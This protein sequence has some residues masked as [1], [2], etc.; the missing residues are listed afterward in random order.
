[1]KETSI[2]QD[3]LDCIGIIENDYPGFKLIC[4]LSGLNSYYFHKKNILDKLHNTIRSRHDLL[5]LGN[6]YLEVFHDKHLKLFDPSLVDETAY[7]K[8]LLTNKGPKIDFLNHSICYVKLPSFNFRFTKKLDRFYAMLPKVIKN[9][10]LIV[11]VRNNSG[12][13]ERMYRGLLK[14][15]V[16]A[17]K[18]RPIV[19]LM[20]EN[21][22]SATEHFILRM[23]S[24]PHVITIGTPTS[25]QLAYGEIKT[26]ITSVMGFKLIM[27]TQLYPE[28]LKYEFKGIE[29]EIMVT[30]KTQID[31]L[32]S[33]L[34]EIP[35]MNLC[36]KDFFNMPF[37]S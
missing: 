30:S 6:E 21:S 17:S 16:S 9:K 22:A 2:S 27:P 26:F 11:D 35:E 4:E 8:N 33:Y 20:N 32:L 3:I 36:K 15:L 5:R 28:Y 24:L 14:I 7:V 10:L 19:I 12:G 18:Q 29:P 34:Y 13:G 31:R 1:M 37:W 23:L 25:G